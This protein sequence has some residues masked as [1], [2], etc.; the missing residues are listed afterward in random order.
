MVVVSG[1]NFLK[2]AQNTFFNIP[3]PHARERGRLGPWPG[4][5]DPDLSRAGP[6]P[7]RPDTCRVPARCA[8]RA[9]QIVQKWI[10]PCAHCP[11]LVYPPRRVPQSLRH[12]DAATLTI[13]VPAAPMT[14]DRHPA[15]PWLQASDSHSHS[16]FAKIN[17]S[18]TKR[19]VGS[20]RVRGGERSHSIP[21]RIIV[22]I[23]QS[24]LAAA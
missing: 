9:P 24:S 1:K 4:P 16:Q 3:D 13:A 2:H 19:L 5:K 17:S 15:Y 7:A 21:S 11:E 18:Q 14:R 10:H 23:F 8:D 20:R 12:A 6:I 22:N